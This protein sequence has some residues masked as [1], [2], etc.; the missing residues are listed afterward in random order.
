VKDCEFKE[1]ELSPIWVQ[2]KLLAPDGKMRYSD[3][4]N[5]ILDDF[6][7]YRNS[8]ELLF[9]H[10]ALSGSRS[11]AV[12]IALNDVHGLGHDSEAMKEEYRYNPFVYR[13]LIETSKQR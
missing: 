1:L 3:C 6:E 5:T 11:P 13:L 9:V 2:L 10:C 7:R 4:A 8:T 12:A